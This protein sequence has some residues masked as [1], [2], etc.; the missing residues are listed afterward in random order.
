MTPTKK[1]NTTH[2]RIEKRKKLDFSGDDQTVHVAGGQ[3]KGLVVNKQ[4]SD[5]ADLGRP[6]LQIGFNCFLVDQKTEKR[7][8]VC[9]FWTYLRGSFFFF[10]TKVLLSP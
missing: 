9:H 3:H 4:I 8:V 2:I 7:V 5:D 6:Q 1:G 10:N